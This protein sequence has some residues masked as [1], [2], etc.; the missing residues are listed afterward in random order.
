MRS[1]VRPVAVL[2]SGLTSHPQITAIE[3]INP[4]ALGTALV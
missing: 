1:F 4:A 2:D 3:A